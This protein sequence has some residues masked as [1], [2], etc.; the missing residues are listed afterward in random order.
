[1]TRQRYQQL[2]RAVEQG[3]AVAAVLGCIVPL[4]ESIDAA[5]EQEDYDRH[6]DARD[7]ADGPEEDREWE[8]RD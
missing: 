7:N 3:R 2:R 4:A 5:I 6:Q 1:M 8:V